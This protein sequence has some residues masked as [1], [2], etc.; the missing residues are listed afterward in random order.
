MTD[1]NVTPEYV[2]ERIGTPASAHHAVLKAL[3]ESV[4]ATADGALG[5]DRD[6]A[7][8]ATAADIA[9]STGLKEWHIKK[10]L[11]PALIPSVVYLRKE[12]YI[13]RDVPKARYDRVIDRYADESF[14][15]FDRLAARMNAWLFKQRARL[16]RSPR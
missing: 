15:L 7:N 10:A 11:M 13:L 1:G 8:T 2:S 14:G 16:G 6:P 4:E 9:A 3:A 12:G 5:K